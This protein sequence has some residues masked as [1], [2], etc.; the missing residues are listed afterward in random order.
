VNILFTPKKIGK[1]T[2]KNRFLMAPMGTCL[3]NENGAVTKK[4]IDYYVKRA[5]GGVGA[6][7]VENA[8]VDT[9][10]AT[11][12]LSI[13]NHHLTKGLKELL[14]QI[15]DVDNDI[16]VFI[17]L[18]KK[19]EGSAADPYRGNEGDR[20]VN[21]LTVEQIH[22]IIAKFATGAQRAK[23]IGFDGIEIH[24]GHHYAIS[25]FLSPHYNKRTDHYGGDLQRNMNFAKEIIIKVREKVGSHYPII[26]RI[27]GSDYVEDGLHVEDTSLITNKLSEVGI[28]AVH[29]TAGV[30]DSAEWTGQPMGFPAGCLVPLAEKIK[31]AVNIPVIAVGKIN[32]PNIAQDVIS[33]GKADFV[34][35]GRAL[36]ADPDFPKKIYENR[37]ED[38]RRCIACRYC[39]SERIHRGFEIRCKV[40]YFTGR[41]EKSNYSCSDLPKNIM[42]VGGGIA[43]LECARILKK[44][45]HNVS[46]YEKGNKLGG[47]LLL[48]KV[49][50]MK[51]EIKYI[52]E[53]QKVQLAKLGINIFLN[54]KV[55]AKLIEKQ[56][57]DTV[58]IATG[59]EPF[60]PK[61]LI[62]FKDINNIVTFKEILSRQCNLFG[63]NVIVIGGGST[64]CET[65]EY[66][67]ENN[68]KCHI[69]IIELFDT[70]ACDEEVIAR[71]L[72]L[73]RL[74]EYGVTFM[75]NTNVI[76][77]TENQVV[78]E[79]NTK[80]D[81]LEADL[82]VLATGL[83]PNQ[84]LIPILE[85][86][87][88]PYY[89]IGDC[90]EPRSITEAIHEAAQI[91]INI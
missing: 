57:P 36:L 26:F 15:K 37:T 39:N 20:G 69:T 46:I 91:A 13:E 3:A 90:N 81:N 25:K 84:E 30:A 52:L 35:L 83:S 70:I 78:I 43:G 5:R 56:K 89:K 4:L 9:V 2:I 24:G 59:A 10:R 18:N 40:N 34:A 66:I 64:G 29:V 11:C 72:L 50:P 51:D 44:R 77:I 82:I 8:L 58:I 55:D 1:I 88:V 71:K 16:K 47:Q 45:G 65:A 42:I 19:T 27:N 54:K 31:K 14:E 61:N 22:E 38:I 62:N 74:N 12:R 48:A 28:D 80:Q 7:I 53:Y 67:Y 68:P 17:Q 63:E 86:K 23:E 6:I 73:K 49:P 60:I 21:E 85:K 87:G 41:E 79:N 76:K 33:Q 75:T 32:N